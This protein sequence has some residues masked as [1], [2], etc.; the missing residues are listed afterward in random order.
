MEVALEAGAD[1]LQSDDARS[2]RS[3]PRPDAF[4][5]VR[6]ALEKNKIPT[7]KPSS[8]RSIQLRHARRAEVQADDA[9]RYGMLDDQDDVQNVYTNTDIPD[10]FTEESRSYQLSVRLS[11]V[12]CGR[13]RQ[14]TDN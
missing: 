1:D 13:R 9:S 2:S 3:T 11:V 6:E 5:Q 14:P 10:E 8:A 7:V 12:G 4:E